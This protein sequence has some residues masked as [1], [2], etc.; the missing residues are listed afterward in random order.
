MQMPMILFMCKWIKWEDNRSNPT[1][2]QN[3]VGFLIVKFHHKLPLLSEPFIFPFQA[4]QVFIFMTLR[5]LV[6][7]LFFER[8]PDLG[9]RC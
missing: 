5:S 6:G 3:D 2:V 9:E 7:K 1:Y 8:K 4:T